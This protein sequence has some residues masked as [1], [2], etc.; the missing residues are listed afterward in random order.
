MSKKQS[1]FVHNQ[2]SK[3]K[4]S[5][6]KGSGNAEKKGG[7]PAMANWFTKAF[8]NAQNDE[9]VK[10]TRNRA[11]SLR[12][13]I[14]AAKTA[15]Q[16]NRK[17]SAV[18]AILAK[19]SSVNKKPSARK[20]T[21]GYKKKTVATGMAAIDK[22]KQNHPFVAKKTTPLKHHKNTAEDWMSRAGKA[23]H[24]HK[25]PTHNNFGKH[26]TPSHNFGKRKTPSHSF[27]KK[28]FTTA[29]KKHH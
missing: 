3:E 16:K 15:S 11:H 12:K 10:S 19:Q 29:K 14:E 2:E 18:A 8:L 20:V 27:G 21:R 22:W 26:K 7:K 23:T 28:G 4:M 17:H 1:H 13:T 24:G 25:T 5:V 9:S 6:N